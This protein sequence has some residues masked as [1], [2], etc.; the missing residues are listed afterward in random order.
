MSSELLTD[1]LPEDAGEVVDDAGAQVVGQA[2]PD[3]GWMSRHRPSLS[4]A[5][6]SRSAIASPVKVVGVGRGG[7]AR[8]VAVSGSRNWTSSR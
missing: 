6:A 7:A 3:V 2:L 4:P 5:R 8:S 1:Y